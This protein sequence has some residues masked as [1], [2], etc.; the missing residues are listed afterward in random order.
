MPAFNIE[1]Y[2]NAITRLPEYVQMSVYYYVKL[3]E[4]L[5]RLTVKKSCFHSFNFHIH[6]L[7]CFNC[8]LLDTARPIE[9][10]LCVTLVPRNGAKKLVKLLVFIKESAKL[11][12]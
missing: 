9:I 2:M 11:P 8:G 4:N 5:C 7:K 1:Q 10:C 6:I 3:K 12:S